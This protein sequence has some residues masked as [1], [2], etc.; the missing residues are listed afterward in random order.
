MGAGMAFAAVLRATQ[1]HA[2]GVFMVIYD[3]FMVYL[4]FS[5]TNP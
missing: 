4:W 1:R 5:L 3:V 2:G